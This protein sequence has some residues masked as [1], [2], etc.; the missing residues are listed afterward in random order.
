[1]LTSIRVFVIVYCFKF[2]NSAFRIVFNDNLERVEHRHSPLRSLVEQ[3]TNAGLKEFVLD[4]AISP[5]DANPLSEVADCSGR[6]PATTEAANSWHSWIV[7]AA[8]V[9][10]THQLIELAFREHGVGHVQARKLVW[11]GVLGVGRLSINQS[12]KGRWSANSNVHS[13]CVMPSMA[14]DWPWAKS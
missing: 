10:F 8:Y 11:C 5:R 1:M 7:P 4:S 9:P 6:H 14:S 3:F 12:Y 2:L 13:E